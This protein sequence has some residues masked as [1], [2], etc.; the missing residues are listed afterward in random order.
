MLNLFY[1]FCGSLTQIGHFRLNVNY[2]KGTFLFFH[3]KFSHSHIPSC[4][5]VIT[6]ICSSF[7]V[8][9]YFD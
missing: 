9:L 5:H 1:A 2:H 6:H 3:P 4:P 8:K 7:F